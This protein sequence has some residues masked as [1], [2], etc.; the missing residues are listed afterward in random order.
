[1]LS[2]SWACPHAKDMGEEGLMASCHH[3]ANSQGM[4]GKMR[5]WPSQEDRGEGLGDFWLPPGQHR[6]YDRQFQRRANIG[7]GRAAGQ[8]SRYHLANPQG[9]AGEF[10]GKLSWAG[11]Q[12]A[13]T[14]AEGHQASIHT[15]VAMPSLSGPQAQATPGS[16]QSLHLRPRTSSNPPN[17]TDDGFW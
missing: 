6:R 16:A 10:R 3:L 2:A 8:F 17:S 15:V 7:K 5:G 4:A 9:T 14:A 12:E 13:R 1:M 11:D